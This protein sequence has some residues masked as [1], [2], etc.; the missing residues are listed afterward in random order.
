MSAYLL[1]QCYKRENEELR[2]KNKELTERND[3]L[4]RQ[5]KLYLNQLLKDIGEE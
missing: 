2:E 3:F 5:I 4:E 1:I